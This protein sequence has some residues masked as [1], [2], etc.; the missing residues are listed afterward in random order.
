[1]NNSDKKDLIVGLIVVLVII[2][3]IIG[4]NIVINSNG[5]NKVE[6]GDPNV[7]VPKIVESYIKDVENYITS[8]DSDATFNEDTTPNP[9][10]DIFELE[11]AIGGPELKPIKSTNIEK[12]KGR[13][14][15]D[16]NTNITEDSCFVV[17]YADKTYYVLYDYLNE[18]ATIITDACEYDHDIVDKAYK[19]RKNEEEVI[20]SYSLSYIDAVE[21]H[22][23]LAQ[24]DN[25]AKKITEGTYTIEQLVE[26]NVKDDKRIEKMP[27]DGTITINSNGA[28][29]TA[30]LI[31]DNYN[32][33]YDAENMD[34]NI[35]IT[36]K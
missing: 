14:V 19:V 18:K 12:G 3:A 27:D 24:V 15:I 29:Q 17:N 30:D 16:Y 22:C 5:S 34:D 23:M 31:Y 33:H 26:L 1:M 36:K 13:I 35:K 20:R 11:Y 6:N 7:E 10:K 21:R 25:N 4:I 9:S 32:A 2:G 8:Y 28:V